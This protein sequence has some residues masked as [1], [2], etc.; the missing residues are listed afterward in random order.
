MVRY[1]HDYGAMLLT[2]DEACISF[3]FYTR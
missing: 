2:A 3:S 1:N